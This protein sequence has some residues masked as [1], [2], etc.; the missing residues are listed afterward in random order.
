MVITVDNVDGLRLSNYSRLPGT[1]V[2]ITCLATPDYVLVGNRTLNCLDTGK[3]D[4]T[5]P[6]CQRK[7]LVEV[8]HDVD[9]TVF[10]AMMAAGI[11]AMI[12]LTMIVFL[13]VLTCFHLN[14]NKT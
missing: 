6:T 4:S 1:Q 14:K 9:L 10:P 8:K 7:E 2:E 5:V 12:M 11:L 13:S 3:W